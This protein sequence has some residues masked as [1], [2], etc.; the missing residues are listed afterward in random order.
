MG[1]EYI[2]ES[3]IALVGLPDALEKAMDPFGYL[4]ERRKYK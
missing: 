4:A 3:G 1:I 2:L